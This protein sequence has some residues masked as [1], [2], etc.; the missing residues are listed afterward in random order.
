LRHLS[1]ACMTQQDQ[2]EIVDNKSH[3]AGKERKGRNM[4][5]GREERKRAK[6]SAS[7]LR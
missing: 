5:G 6:V 3:V 1:K 2:P 7:C 4:E